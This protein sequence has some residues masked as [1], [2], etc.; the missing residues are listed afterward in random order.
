MIETEKVHFSAATR[1]RNTADE[2]RVKLSIQHS[3]PGFSP[4]MKENYFSHF[5]KGFFDRLTCL[6]KLALTYVQAGWIFISPFT[7]KLLCTIVYGACIVNDDYVDADYNISGSRVLFAPL[8]IHCS[9]GRPRNGHHG[10][11][12]RSDAKVLPG[13]TK[14]F[15]HS[16]MF[17]L[18]V[19]GQLG[20]HDHGN[21][22]PKVVGPPERR[23]SFSRRFAIS[24][25]T[26]LKIHILI[27]SC[28]VLLQ[29]RN[30]SALTSACSC[31]SSYFHVSVSSR[32]NCAIKF[33][34][35]F[36]P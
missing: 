26:T 32:G 22:P 10:P 1:K 24:T 15:N 35:F 33:F 9:R 11:A 16:Q 29:E 4:P 28:M 25:A 5:P 21:A 3:T 12:V 23:V 14:A 7:P 30:L 34:Y 17:L 8:Q 6:S 2:D 18:R 19:D 20:G 13:P 36:C 31:R 27:M